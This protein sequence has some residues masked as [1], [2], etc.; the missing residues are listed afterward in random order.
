MLLISTTQ[1]Y[2][3]THVGSVETLVQVNVIGPLTWAE[4]GPVIVIGRTGAQNPR[5]PAAILDGDRRD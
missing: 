4:L 5:T 2:D 1:S 3:Q